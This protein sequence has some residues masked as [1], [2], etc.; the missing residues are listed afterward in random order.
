MMIS[1]DQSP[2]LCRCE[3]FPTYPRTYDLVHADGLLTLEFSQN[4]HSR[5][6][7]LD[8]FV[9]ID[10]LLRPEVCFQLWYSIFLK[11]NWNM[12]VYILRYHHNI[13][14]EMMKIYI[15]ILEKNCTLLRV[16]SLSHSWVQLHEL[17]SDHGVGLGHHTRH[18][19]SH[20]V[21]KRS[22]S[23]AEMG[24]SSHRDRK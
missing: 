6:G 5:C 2:Y 17:F 18:N 12:I 13:C 11:F 1:K 4:S 7:M 3:A 24:C 9:E 19:S 8:L 16:C 10:R 23:A 15:C 22:R 21:S 20:R 14:M